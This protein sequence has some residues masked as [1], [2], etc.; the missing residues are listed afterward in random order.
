[1]PADPGPG[2][3]ELVQINAGS[4]YPSGEIGQ[5]A[6]T[7]PPLGAELILLARSQVHDPFAGFDW[8]G[9][10]AS[11]FGLTTVKKTA[12]WVALA[13]LAVG[14]GA[15]IWLGS[16]RILHAA[17]AVGWLGLAYVVC[18]Q[19]AV[20]V[21]LG[22]AWWVVCPGASPGIMIWGR[23]V[24]EGALTCLPLSAFGGLAIGTRALMLGGVDFADAAASSVV[25]VIAEG[26]SLAPFLAFGLVVLLA[27]QPGSSLAIPLGI[28]IAALV[29]G[30]GATFLF[31]NR[32]ARVLRA[33]IEWL[34]RR[35]VRDVR[36]RADELHRALKDLFGRHGRVA[37]GSTIHLVCWCAGAGNVWI[38]YHL[39]G[40]KPGVLDALAIESIFSG[41]LSF[42]FLVPGGLGVQ[43]LTYVGI[44]RLFGMPAPLSLALSLL[45]RARDLVI[46][47]PPLLVWQALEARR[48]RETG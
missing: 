28:G 30:G 33:A 48:L 37:A 41:V 7:K 31:R 34:L 47:A 1:L 39:L 26:I 15:V 2:N 13:G 27:R 20:F 10:R 32:L 36:Q 8:R 9:F 6:R 18:W 42:G 16:G 5:N 44:G 25:D 14:T 11:G 46:G 12:I 43:E 35:T 23:L 40:A 38:G 3:A 45:R 24:R 29:L 17:L 19:L 21:F 22:I 4:L